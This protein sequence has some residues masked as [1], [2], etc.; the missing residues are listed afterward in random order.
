MT[1]E[2]YITDLV[3]QNLTGKQIVDL[4]S[5]FGDEEAKTN[6]VATQGANVTSTQ[7]G[8]SDTDSQLPDGTA[9]LPKPGQI[10]S[11]P[12]GFEYK[13]EID[14]NDEGQGIYYSRKAGEE[15]WTDTNKDTTE[16]GKVAKYSIANMFGHA[17][18]N[19][20]KQKKY[21][22]QLD[23]ADKAKK[24]KK[25]AI[26]AI[27][28][29]DKKGVK[30]LLREGFKGQTDDWFD[31]D[32]SK[33]VEAGAKAFGKTVGFGIDA[34]QTVILEPAA[35]FLDFTGI[36]NFEDFQ[37]DSFV[38]VDF[39]KAINETVTKYAYSTGAVDGIREGYDFDEETEDLVESSVL[40]VAA[41]MMALPQLIAD[42]KKL[43]GDFAEEK[44]P[45]GVIDFLGSDVMKSQFQK[46]SMGLKILN[47]L[48]QQ[49]VV[50][51]AE[52]LFDEFTKKSEQL[53]MTLMDFG[54]IGMVNTLRRVGETKKRDKN[55]DFV[56]EKDKN[57]EFKRDKDGEYIHVKSDIT[58]EERIGAFV[59]GAA[60]ITSSALGSLP[61]V[62][63]S[64]IPVV[65]IA[66]IVVGEAARTNMESKKDG[67]PLDGARL[68]HAYVIGASEGLLELVTKKIG[69]NMLKNL[70]GASKPLIQKTLRQYALQVFKEF[71]QE[72]L[73]ETA[74][75]LIN[76]AADKL[77]KDE[78]DE[79]FPAWSEVMDTF[80]IGGVMGGGMSASGAG[81]SLLRS[82]ID[83]RNIKGK[84]KGTQFK[85]L[86][87][88]FDSP[89]SVIGDTITGMED[90]NAKKDNL[91][92]VEVEAVTSESID[93]GET[94]QKAKGQESIEDQKVDSK[95]SKTLKEDVAETE[96]QVN[97]KGSR[98]GTIKQPGT[99]VNTINAN[100]EADNRF[101]IITNPQTEK[102]LNTELKRKVASGEMTTDK[103]NEIKANFKAQQGANNQLQRI[104]W[105]RLYWSLLELKLIDLLAEAES[106]RCKE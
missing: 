39:D 85:S 37:D 77:Y 102:F 42:Q 92:D 104:S 93:K 94:Q 76:Q 66:S 91:E 41:G 103:A 57:G 49:S 65:G 100:Q 5:K 51:A 40:T 21:T 97:E 79:W 81:M 22:E 2:E 17:D 24:E 106:A 29:D 78:V 71:G 16:R 28:K 64:M 69:G 95:K 87:G 7:P 20:E 86:S 1:K 30:G 31:F 96:A 89:T 75:L 38:G 60:R 14:P 46:S 26:L 62:A 27:T 25:E 101:D 61:S 56:Y 74:T 70:R 55:G 50:E 63:Q 72:G 98:Q 58:K 84:L 9:G 44:L 35:A 105:L 13:F 6:D 45:Q 3:S 68:G 8:A 47:E 36:M 73:S 59:T 80:V 10:I 12:D 32:G 67:R 23:A 83:Y 19:E 82:T 18:F 43:L 54:N 99:K 34:Y 88:L 11:K 48:S 15:N 33:F 4:A 52:P 53:N 90:S